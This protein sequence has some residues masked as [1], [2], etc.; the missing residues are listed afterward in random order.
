MN[1]KIKACLSLVVFAT[2]P[3]CN[4]I[5]LSASSNNGSEPQ[6]LFQFQSNFWMNLH[7]ALFRESALRRADG[8]QSA[9]GRPAPLPE[10]DLSEGEKRTWSNAINYYAQQLVGRRLLLNEQ[11]IQINN[12]LSQQAD[13]EK[14]HSPALQAEFVLILEK[15]HRV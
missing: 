14:L 10:A 15:A 1:K 13:P 4:S 6:A 3:L 5:Q 9:P 7:H 2:L 8:Q 12:N 11:L